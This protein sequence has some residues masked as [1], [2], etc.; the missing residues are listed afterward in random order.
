M[1]PSDLPADPV[2][3]AASDRDEGAGDI[4]ARRG[5]SR[6]IWVV[7]GVAALVWVLDRVTKLLA[8]EH[9]KGRPPVQVVGEWL[10]FTYVENTGAAFS[11]GT[12]MTVVFTLIA[13]VVVVVILRTSRKLGSVGWAIALGGLLGGALGNLTD[14]LTREPGFGRGSVVDFIALPNYPV[15]NVADM[16]VVG[17]AI[18]MIVLA[19]R[20]IEIDGSR[21]GAR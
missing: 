16:A 13:I 15:F 9:L 1:T 19:L 4:P 6:L 10:Q 18:L 14:R 11:L 2:A 21:A 5:A 12:G 7:L 20:G 8:I 3:P 17:S